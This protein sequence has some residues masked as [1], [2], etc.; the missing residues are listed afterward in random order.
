MQGAKE[1]GSDG[2]RLKGELWAACV[3]QCV[4]H[5]MHPG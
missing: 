3:H 2:K 1:T 5:N 4:S